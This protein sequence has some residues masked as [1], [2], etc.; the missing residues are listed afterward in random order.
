MLLRHANTSDVNL[1][2]G[3]NKKSLFCASSCGDMNCVQ[4]FYTRHDIDVDDRSTYRNETDY[5]AYG[6][7]RDEI[8]KLIVYCKK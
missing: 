6:E 5:V 7:H 1:C 3:N 2:D 4:V 8:H